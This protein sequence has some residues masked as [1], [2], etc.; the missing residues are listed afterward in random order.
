MVELILRFCEKHGKMGIFGGKSQKFDLNTPIMVE[1][2]SWEKTK[3]SL[4]RVPCSTKGSARSCSS[5][6]SYL[7][8]CL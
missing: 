6:L 7:V 1:F 3:F 8:L 5:Y 4:E 2:L